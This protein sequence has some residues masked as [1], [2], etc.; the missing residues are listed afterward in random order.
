MENA[1]IMP[2]FIEIHPAANKVRMMDTTEYSTLLEDIRENGQLVPA[3]MLE[4][5]LIDGRNRMKVCEELGIELIVEEHSANAP[6]PER[7]VWS[8]NAARRQLTAGQ[9]TA[10]A[11]DMANVQKHCNRYTGPKVD[12]D[13]NSIYKPVTQQEAAETFGVDSSALRNFRQVEKETPEEAERIRQGETSVSAAYNKVKKK[14]KAGKTEKVVPI[15]P[16]VKVDTTPEL[17]WDGLA[18]LSGINTD[19]MAQALED[20]THPQYMMARG[21]ESSRERLCTEL[22]PLS[23]PERKRTMKAFMSVLSYEQEVFQAEVKATAPKYHKAAEA[24]LKVELDKQR[25]ITKELSKKAN[26][27]DKADFR[28]IRGVLHSDRDV[29]EERRGKAFDLFLKLSPLFE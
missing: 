6:D 15:T 4:G 23:K 20:Y 12:R 9:K 7:L 19:L 1:K 27:F 13:K 14:R 29:G 18:V 16:D 28:F 8:Y 25:K 22:A 24:K 3:V 21:L 2:R 26:G 10:L 17:E 5:K 11:S